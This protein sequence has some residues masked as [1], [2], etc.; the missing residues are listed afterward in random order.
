MAYRLVIPSTAAQPPYPRLIRVRM[1]NTGQTVSILSLDGGGVRGISTLYILKDLMNQIRRHRRSIDPQD[2]KPSP[3]PC[4]IFDLIC[5]TST[6]GLIAIMLGR[7]DMVIPKSH[8]PLIVRPW[9][10]LS[11]ITKDC[12]KKFSLPP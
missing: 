2:D 3:R 5:G 12:P 9:M 1:A 11:I 6:G 7:L 10:K 8:R 4:D